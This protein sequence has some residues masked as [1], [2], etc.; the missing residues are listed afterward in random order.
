ML[1]AKHLDIALDYWREKMTLEKMEILID[2]FHLFEDCGKMSF[3]IFCVQTYRFQLV[4]KFLQ[5]QKFRKLAWKEN[6]YF[7]S[8]PHNLP[9]EH[10]KWIIVER[11]VSSASTLFI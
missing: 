4:Q 5:D 2:N 10:G 8:Q 11:I 1:N 7:D 3:F 6:L 9:G